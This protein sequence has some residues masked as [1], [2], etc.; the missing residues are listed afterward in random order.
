VDAALFEC[1]TEGILNTALVHGLSGLR[2]LDV[3][4]ALGWKDQH[5]VAMALPVLTQHLQCSFGQWNR[6][7]LISFPLAY[8][9]R[10]ETCGS[11]GR[12]GARLGD[13]FLGSI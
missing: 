1:P 11:A 5:R 13:G 9:E 2:Q 3:V 10:Q 4:F 12:A 7:V 6:P 8:V